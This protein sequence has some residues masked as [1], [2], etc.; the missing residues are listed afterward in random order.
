MTTFHRIESLAAPFFLLY[1]N[2]LWSRFIFIV[3][4]SLKPLLG[5]SSHSGD[6][7]QGQPF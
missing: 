4:V 1:L 3:D 7:C 6:P 2:L 5:N